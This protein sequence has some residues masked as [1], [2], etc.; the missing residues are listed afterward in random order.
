M[1]WHPRVT[2][3]AVIRDRDGRH[4]LVEEQPAGVTVFNQP[5]GHLEED[6]SLLDAVIR[7]VREET[8]RDFNPT[9]LV[10]IYRWRV[11]PD[12]D[13]YLRFCFIG[14]AGDER[15][16]LTRDPDILATRW[17]LPDE[18]GATGL[19]ARSP[20]VRQCMDDAIAGNRFPLALLHELGSADVRR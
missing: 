8:C 3:A 10:G 11:P 9:A 2:V 5:A 1:R 6:E 14:E 19:A 15:S 12:G 17:V 16:D 7:E 20:L 18:L 13:T 4:L